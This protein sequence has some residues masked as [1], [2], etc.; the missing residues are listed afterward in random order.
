MDIGSKVEQAREKIKSG[1]KSYFEANEITGK[2]QGIQQMQ[3][4]IN[5]L[6]LALNYNS[7]TINEFYK[8]MIINLVKTEEENLQLM[9]SKKDKNCSSRARTNTVNNVA[10]SDNQIIQNK[11]ANVVMAAKPNVLWTDIAGQEKAK[12]ALKE[13]VILPNKFPKFFNEIVQPWKGILLYGPPG[14]GK[15]TLAQACATECDAVFYKASAA[16]LMSKWVGES[17]KSIKA[18]FENARSQE[19]GSIIFLDEIDALVSSRNSDSSNEASNRVKCEF[20]AQ[21]Q[22]I[23]NK[24]RGKVLVLGATN[25]PWQLDEAMIRR[26]EKRIYIDL[27]KKEDRMMLLQHKMRKNNHNIVEKQWKCLADMTKNFSGADLGVLCKDAAMEKVRLA[28]SSNQFVKHVSYNK[29]M[30]TAFDQ[31]EKI[32]GE[33]VN[34]DF[35]DLPDGSQKLGTIMYEDFTTALKRTKATVCEADLVDFV[36][37]T[38]EFGVSAK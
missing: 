27:P 12:Q 36:K 21:M 17:E 22:G 30:Y 20:L 2:N 4:G 37:W 28:R 35:Y 3:D 19:K 5:M 38:K 16:D 8:N 34:K 23:D 14:T 24:Q 25:I 6:K 10:K 33:I 31:N 9:I 29:T 18:L 32:K 13:A 26:F 7:S 15:T 11:V 1:K